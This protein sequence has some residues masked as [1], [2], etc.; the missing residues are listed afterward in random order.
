MNDDGTSAPRPERVG[1]VTIREVYT[2]ARAGALG[3]VRNPASPAD[4][5]S[6]RSRTLEIALAL[7]IVVEA[8]EILQ[9]AAAWPGSRSGG[10]RGLVLPAA[11][12]VGSGG[13]LEW[14][15]V[16]AL[17]EAVE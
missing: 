5:R 8:I 4:L 16:L 14:R 2:H 11:T 12:M 15:I 13:E 17:V 7:G 6:V 10:W 9:R 1:F 3:D